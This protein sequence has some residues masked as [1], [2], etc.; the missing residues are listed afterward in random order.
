MDS[1]KQPPEMDMQGNL[2]E[3]WKKWK[4]RFAFYIDASPLS[5]KA[6]KAKCSCLLH[7]IGQQGL[8]IYNSFTI[9]DAKK[10]DLTEVQA[11]FDA[12]F[13]P[14]RN[15]TVERHKFFIRSQKRGETIDQYVTALTNLAGSCEFEALKK[16]LIRDRVICGIHSDV[17]RNRLLREDELDLDKSVKICRAAELVDQQSKSISSAYS[18]SHEVNY[19]KHKPKRKYP[20]PQS[21]EQKGSQSNCKYCKQMHRKRECPAYGVQCNKCG[22]MNHFAKACQSTSQ[23]VTF[24]KQHQRFTHGNPGNPQKPTQR[25]VYECDIEVEEQ[26]ADAYEDL[27]I[28]YIDVEHEVNSMCVD[29]QRNKWQT[30]VQINDADVTIQID[31]GA[32]C[33]VMSLS[34][35]KSIG[36]LSH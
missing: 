36:K 2:A 15:I 32:K 18:E 6:D 20:Q 29:N 14:K 22:K 35:L 23:P 8:D 25:R 31:T 12:Y 5:T 33:N 27:Y 13:S 16:S 9:D 19:V 1:L 21:R 4:Q 26:C 28:G 17:V 7:C 11:K 24:R 3:N 30:V 10:L 34:T